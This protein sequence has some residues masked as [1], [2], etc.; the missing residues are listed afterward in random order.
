MMLN[1][2]RRYPGLI[3]LVLIALT[4]LPSGAAM[5]DDIYRQEDEDGNVTYT[6]EPPDDESEPVELEPLPQMN[7]PTSNRSSR[8]ADDPGE[9]QDE[10][11]DA[12]PED[13]Y[14]SLAISEPEH[15]SAFWR[16]GGEVTVRIHSEP[17]LSEGHQYQLEFDGETIEETR[18]TS[19]T[20]ENVDRG[21][22]EMSVHILDASGE[23]IQSSDRTRF[24]LHRPSQLN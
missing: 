9:E 5:G 10:S 8:P 4:L 15:D 23:V 18:N 7:I 20:L 22:H 1:R 19:I 16:G 14:E 6:D 21:T 17:E 12:E 2:Y 13:A 3:A 24:T 11:G